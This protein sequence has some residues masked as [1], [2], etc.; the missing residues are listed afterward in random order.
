MV[1]AHGPARPEFARE[2]AK[3]YPGLLRLRLR[4]GLLAAFSVQPLFE[5]AVFRPFVL[6]LLFEFGVAREQLV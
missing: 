2:G 1:C 3:A 5:I 4:N 6:Q